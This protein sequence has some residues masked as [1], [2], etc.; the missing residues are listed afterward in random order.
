MKKADAGEFFLR[1][2]ELMEAGASLVVEAY[3]NDTGSPISTN[4][5][6]WPVAL[7]RQ[8]GELAFL[9]AEHAAVPAA[10]D[11]ILR[12]YQAALAPAEEAKKRRWRQLLRRKGALPA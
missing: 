1:L 3:G 6:G 4:R 8:S 7:V 10:G 9:G 12:L 5:D 11:L 2:A